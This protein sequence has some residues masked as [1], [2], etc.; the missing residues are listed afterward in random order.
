MHTLRADLDYGFAEG[1]TTYG[2]IGVKVWLY[3]GDIMEHDPMARDKRLA[4][5]QGGAPRELIKKTLK[6]K[7]FLAFILN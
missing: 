2:I 3:K 6:V 1:L 5:A 4:E 7:K